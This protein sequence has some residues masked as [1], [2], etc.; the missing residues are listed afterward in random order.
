MDG[1][2]YNWLGAAPGPEPVNQTSLTYT[3][4][5]SIF[6]FDV[7]GKVTMTVNFLSPVY[8]D[9]VA[10]QSLQFSYI[11][12]KVMS[13]DGKSHQVRTYMDVT[14]GMSWFYGHCF[15]AAFRVDDDHEQNG[16][17]ATSTKL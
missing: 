2:T 9:D 5:Q 17:A 14:G 16:P 3:S 12:I 8:P 1:V 4:T 11:S 13:A 10:R 15:V 7:A 6:T